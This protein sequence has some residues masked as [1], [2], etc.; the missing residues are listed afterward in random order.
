MTSTVED[1]KRTEKEM[2]NNLREDNGVIQYLKEEAIQAKSRFIQQLDMY[3]VSS[4]FDKSEMD[5]HVRI[6][7]QINEVLSSMG[8]ASDPKWTSI[9]IRCGCVSPN[10][11]TKTTNARNSGIGISSPLSNSNNN[12]NHTNNTSNIEKPK[13]NKKTGWDIDATSSR[14]RKETKS[15]IEIQNEEA[16][17]EKSESRDFEVELSQAS[18]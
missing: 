18:R 10:G 12:N 16:Q 4:S 2:L 7:T 13:Q 9:M 15:L 5:T 6:L 14:I 3:L 8:M 1:M 17:N 11:N